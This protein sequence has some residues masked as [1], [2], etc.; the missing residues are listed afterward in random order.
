MEPT[1]R[2]LELCFGVVVV[3]SFVEPCEHVGK[4]V[5]E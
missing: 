2:S 5:Q 4:L 3:L 1:V